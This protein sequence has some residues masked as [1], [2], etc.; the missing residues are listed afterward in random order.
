[1][2]G[3]FIYELGSSLRRSKKKFTLNLFIFGHKKTASMI[4]IR[5]WTFTA[6]QKNVTSALFLHPLLTCDS[7]LL[8]EEE[9]LLLL[10]LACRPIAVA[11]PDRL[12][13][14]TAVP[15]GAPGSS[16]PGTTAPSAPLFQSFVG[17]G[18]LDYC[19]TEYDSS[20]LLFNSDPA[21]NPDFAMLL[22]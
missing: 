13:F 1:M 18:R 20:F 22:Q 15:G 17:L 14:A 9:L 3:G 4:R 6:N 10:W 12:P 11:V 2:V 5:L 7:L 21:P 19:S 8:Q 16:R